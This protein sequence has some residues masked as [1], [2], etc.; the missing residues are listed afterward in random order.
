MRN[1]K[2]FLALVLAMMMAM[3]LMITANAA[4]E[5]DNA[6][7]TYP[8]GDSVTPAF[9]E[10]VDV[11]SG[12]KVFKG[13]DTGNFDA[14]ATINRAETAAI[15]YRLMTADVEDAQ[16]DLFRNVTHPFTDVQPTDWYAGYIGFLWNAGI[17]KGQTATTFNP[18]G[19][20]TGY[21]ALAMILRAVGYDQNHEFEGT[22]WVV[23]VASIAQRKGILKDVET[24]NY[25]GP[26]LYSAARRDVV[27]S[28]L[29]R[30]AAF[31]PQV[32][33]TS[34]F[35]YTESG[36]TGGPSYLPGQSLLNP[37]LGEQNFGLR[38][39]HG[40]VVGNQATGETST[41][42][43][44]KN[45]PTAIA[46]ANGTDTALTEVNATSY[47]YE[48]ITYTEANNSTGNV[49]FT[50]TVQSFNWTTDL[51]LFNHA[52]RVW[53]DARDGANKD[54][55]ALYDKADKVAVVHATDANLTYDSVTPANT[56]D[57]YKKATSSTDD[58]V[59]NWKA[60][61]FTMDL[62]ST[63]QYQDK[64]GDAA[65]PEN[66]A[67]DGSDRG[68]VLVPDN[69]AYFNW[70][71]TRMSPKNRAINGAGP[72]HELGL[73]PINKN[74]GTDD[75][76][77]Y[78]LISN[79][80]SNLDVV[81]PLDLTFSRIS[82]S[83]TTT[84]GSSVGVINGNGSN[85]GA[86]G[87]A[88]TDSNPGTNAY[89]DTFD[90]VNPTAAN[91]ADYASIAVKNLLN[92]PK[93]DLGT[94][95][96]A[97]TI[98]GTN[99]TRNN[100]AA[101]ITAD[102]NTS[103]FGFA[104]KE[105]GLRTAAST[106][107]L[108]KT[109][110]TYY[111]QL[112]ENTIK[113]T[114]TVWK[115]DPSNQDVYLNDGSVLHQSVYAEATDGSFM[116][117]GAASTTSGMEAYDKVAKNFRL[118]SGADAYTFTLDEQGNYI[119]WETAAV[120]ANFVYGTY[121]DWTSEVASSKFDYPMVYVNA[122]GQGGLKKNIT[123]V[124]G[125][126]MNIDEYDDIILPKHDRS[127]DSGGNAAGFVKGR[128]IGYAMND[129]GELDP[130]LAGT[131][132][133]QGAVT[134]FGVAAIT[135][136]K[137]SL[138]VGAEGVSYKSVANGMFLTENTKFVIVDG[139]GTDNQSVV[140]KNGIS[141]LMKGMD[142]VVIDAAAA[143][144]IAAADSKYIS[145][146]DG[147]P[148]DPAN[149]LY[150]MVYFTR[151]S[152]TYDQNYDPSA[153]EIKTVFLPKDCVKFNPSTTSSLVFVGS[154]T[155][156]WVN[157]NNGIWATQFTVYQ[158]GEGK[159][160]WIKGHYEDQKSAGVDCDAEQVFVNGNN[161]FYNLVE[162]AD[163]AA[164]G[165]PIYTIAFVSDDAK[166]LGQYWGDNGTGT[167]EVREHARGAAAAVAAPPSANVLYYKATTY[168]QQAGYIGTA[169]EYG[170]PIT[171][172][173]YNVGAAVIK[174]LDTTDYPGIQDNNLTT[175]NGASSLTDNIGV[176]VSCIL[177]GDLVV[178]CVYVNA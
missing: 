54:T 24:A 96:A 29:F 136:D 149:N 139:A 134:D 57:L 103:D 44:F 34:A 116:P 150:E 89:F 146:D 122:D 47:L 35:Q 97:I 49:T 120:T 1:L 151:G 27:A 174:N 158:N 12:M 111:Y 92:S 102:T 37:S 22:N 133:E 11:L 40:V 154:V 32:I 64:N 61:G 23:S 13:R 15:I 132:F 126:V 135:V 178:T 124:D 67:A 94:K 138:K 79:S 69:K 46:G 77:L 107:T 118:Q 71:F 73:S 162:T 117:R 147:D 170:P 2:K 173:L 167:G 112:T 177:D 129:S 63:I 100:N 16:A 83:N 17:I 68:W 163:K 157:S 115:V 88:N 165:N 125:K 38:Y 7:K 59:N 66:P 74:N 113:K 148:D 127:G 172:G 161:V 131:G 21:E 144:T 39:A 114:A 6:T 137:D 130:T 45:T 55:Y 4:N 28:L 101:R 42:I 91:A 14:G 142:S 65:D 110:S 143:T 75:W 86:T 30:T 19:K 62:G 93:T 176:P 8:D 119:Y 95:V 56:G 84:G 171:A 141:D 51:R 121:I 175:L 98:T 90:E 99:G 52:V 60:P 108:T 50:S 140:I 169:A 26:Y 164:D 10:A 58:V 128:Y 80:G 33:Y 87:A 18:Y 25:G 123:K 104:T 5:A 153:L 81:I 36:M 72:G 20:V 106:G 159:D 70:G 82:Q 105:N 76:G 152:F 166:L 78:L 85:D 31:V 109:Q 155:P 168:S 41:K 53:F 145:A 9:T 160:V 3:S 43:G 48:S 156:K